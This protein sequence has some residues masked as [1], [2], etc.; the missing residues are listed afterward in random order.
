[1]DTSQ[2]LQMM[3]GS[4]ALKRRSR[5]TADV[6]LYWLRR[7]IDFLSQ[8][9]K[10]A[11]REQKIS[12]FL[13]ML[14]SH[15]KVAAS[16]QKQALCAVVYFYKNVL[17]VELG[18]LSPLWSSR[19]KRLPEV[20]SRE[21]VW[22][23]L[24]AL[25]G[26]G[27]LWAALMYGCGLRLGE[28]CSLRVKDV[29]FDRQVI[30]VR[31]GKGD[32]DRVLPMPDSLVKPLENQLLRSRSEYNSYEGSRPP[33]SLS[34]ALDRKYPNAP[35]EWHWFWVFPASAT[36][37]DPKWEGKLH[38]IHDSAVRKRI[39]RGIKGA[40]ISKHCGCHTFRH[41]FATHWLE[42]A[43]G[44]HELAIRQLQELLGHVDVRTTM[45]YLHLMKG[46]TDVPS[47]LDTRAVVG[48]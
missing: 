2:A 5:R 20:F 27:W 26:E 33:V 32:K 24:D 39:K 16:T 37:R 43:S 4:L 6:Y 15:E 34:G 31:G 3:R 46:R 9:D 21:E 1:M 12:Q 28:V 29:D 10:G 7:F 35:F 45:V 38:H 44:S 23:V 11:T 8:C 36:A 19:P 22:A 18:D 40:G 48:E 47:P 30:M 13:T 25:R 42:N 41:S 14:A 17:H